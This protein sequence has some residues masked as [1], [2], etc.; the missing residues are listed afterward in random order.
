MQLIQ[1]C[2]HT[3]TCTKNTHRT[4]T[5][6][7]CTRP[8]GRL[9][10]TGRGAPGGTAHGRG[11]GVG[12]RAALHRHRVWRHV[13]HSR[14]R[15]RLRP[16][17]PG[18]VSGGAARDRKRPPGRNKVVLCPKFVKAE[19]AAARRSTG[20]RRLAGRCAGGCVCC[21]AAAR[22][23]GA[24][25]QCA[26]VWDG[27]V[28]I[29]APWGRQSPCVCRLRPRGSASGGVPQ[30]RL[31]RPVQTDL[32]PLLC[33]HSVPCCIVRRCSCCRVAAVFRR[34]GTAHMGPQHCHLPPV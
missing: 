13:V 19:I 12:P 22:A 11:A 31:C 4:C 21:A 32:A 18:A 17:H 34:R 33:R 7:P 8:N 20:E 15:T 28:R 27:A 23:A 1:A 16:L 25:Q 2:T 24:L 5:A 3:H 14:C 30:R 29:S 10:C 26:G 9:T 6:S